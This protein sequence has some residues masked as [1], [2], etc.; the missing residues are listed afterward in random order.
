MAAANTFTDTAKV[1]AKGQITIPKDVR[2]ALGVST[3]SR[4]T[5]LVEGDSV[6]M[7]NSAVFAMRSLQKD[8]AGEAE[9]AG[10]N[11]EEAVTGY[12]KSVRDEG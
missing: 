6:R 3:G 1:M 9:R 7:F 2:E 10:L 4:V 11:S 8:M 5:F 12:V